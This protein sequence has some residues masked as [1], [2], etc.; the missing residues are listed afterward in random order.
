MPWSFVL[1]SYYYLVLLGCVDYHNLFVNFSFK[2][3]PKS[4]FIK[5]DNLRENG[6][7]IEIPFERDFELFDKY[8]FFSVFV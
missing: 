4:E 1:C 7:N 6:K 2:I 5:K 8:H 3:I